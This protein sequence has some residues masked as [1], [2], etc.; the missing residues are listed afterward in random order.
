MA[1]ARLW[2]RARHVTLGFVHNPQVP[3]TLEGWSVLHQMFRIRWDV[4]KALARDR[5]K[6]VADEAAALFAPLEG[7]KEGPSALVQLLGH[8]G[9][10]MLIH[11]RKR[12][13]D[14]S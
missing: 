8:K 13:D 11:F 12:F 14:L 6:K 7:S 3:E 4:W 2:R 5:R 9:D 1:A 10:L